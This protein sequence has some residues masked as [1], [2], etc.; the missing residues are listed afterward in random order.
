MPKRFDELITDAQE[1]VVEVARAGAR[2]ARSI[3]ATVGDAEQLEVQFGLKFSTEGKIIFA[4]A[5]TEVS[6]NVK[7]IYGRIRNFEDPESESLPD[8]EASED[9]E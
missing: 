2:A 5:G 1:V 9:V 3:A 4:S 8:L 6:L 7:L